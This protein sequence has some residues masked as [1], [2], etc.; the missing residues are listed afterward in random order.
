MST[1]LHNKI[2][3]RAVLLRIAFPISYN[4]FAVFSTGTVPI[5]CTRGSRTGNRLHQTVHQRH[6]V[7]TGTHVWLGWK[8]EEKETQENYCCLNSN[9]GCGKE[10]KIKCSVINWYF[11]VFKKRS[12]KV[13][14]FEKLQHHLLVRICF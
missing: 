8:E 10:F 12:T 14:I 7:H 4:L 1:V 5:S 11:S 6:H 2:V 3:Q 13:W 9:Y